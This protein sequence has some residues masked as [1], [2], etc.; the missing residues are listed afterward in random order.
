MGFKG[1]KMADKLDIS[2]V[3]DFNISQSNPMSNAFGYGFLERRSKWERAK[4]I[5]LNALNQLGLEYKKEIYKKSESPQMFNTNSP[6]VSAFTPDKINLSILENQI[7]LDPEFVNDFVD[8]FG[9]AIILTVIKNV[10]YQKVFEK[11][12]IS[13]ICH[14]GKE[15]FDNNE[16][17]SVFS[18]IPF[19]DKN[20]F[21]ADAEKNI[22]LFKEKLLNRL[23]NKFTLH[24]TAPTSS[25]EFIKSRISTISEETFAKYIE[26]LEEF[27]KAD[28]CLD[29]R[30]T[31]CRAFIRSEKKEE[32]EIHLANIKELL[33]KRNLEE[34][35]L[36]LLS[37]ENN[38][39]FFACINNV[40]GF[41]FALKS[42][43]Q[44][45][46]QIHP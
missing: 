17:P 8:H 15:R 43:F 4:G 33:Q 13:Y 39:F 7:R 16:N 9:K 12:S 29:K 34:K 23:A 25:S 14:C 35:G 27:Y 30:K 38:K 24:S 46:P 11:I 40:P 37:S 42:R 18:M 45:T 10:D 31:P 44:N 6:S 41:L 1:R 26:E 36:S 2:I 32:I 3:I 28:W 20:Q 21:M 22:S 19:K 5:F